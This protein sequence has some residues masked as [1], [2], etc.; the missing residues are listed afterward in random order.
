MIFFEN[1]SIYP[2]KDFTEWGVKGALKLVE[3]KLCG[4]VYF[5]P[6]LNGAGLSVFHEE[7][8]QESVNDTESNEK[9]KKM[10]RLERDFL[11]KH[12]KN[13][14]SILDIG[15]GGGRISSRVIR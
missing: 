5:K 6:K 11:L 1:K 14:K 10:F 3:C 12:I 8:N 4:L 2:E 15:C 7:H 9:R 13:Q